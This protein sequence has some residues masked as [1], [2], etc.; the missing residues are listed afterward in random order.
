MRE[1]KGVMNFERRLPRLKIVQSAA[2][3][4]DLSNAYVLRKKRHPARD[5]RLLTT[6]DTIQCQIEKSCNLSVKK[7]VTCGPHFEAICFNMYC[8]SS[9]WQHAC[10]SGKNAQEQ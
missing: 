8:R 10:R 5:G 7:I 2:R 1:L 9:V 4:G 6:G 3:K